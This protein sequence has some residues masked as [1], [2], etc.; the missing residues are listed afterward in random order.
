MRIFMSAKT[1]PWLVGW[2][3][4]VLAHVLIFLAVGVYLVM[5][6]DTQKPSGNGGGA[7]GGG[8]SSPSAR[9]D[10][11]LTAQDVRSALQSHRRRL[12]DLS[13]EQKLQRLRRKADALE[14]IPT[15]RVDL[16]A[17]FIEKAMGADTRRA[18]AP[19]PK[20]KGR[21]DPD[22]ATLYDIERATR[23][24]REVL[25]YTWVDAAGR[26]V[27]SERAAEQVT[28]NDRAAATAMDMARSMPQLRRLVDAAIRIGTTQVQRQRRPRSRP[29]TTQPTR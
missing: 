3:V 16:A 24:G 17:A 2:A 8:G 7:T 29:A 28:G 14:K 13:A 26:S 11:P 15:E 9:A 27:T 6:A 1:K 21:F 22:T 25:K 4:S 23:N 18:Y 20:A 5:P 12:A 10:S 19:D